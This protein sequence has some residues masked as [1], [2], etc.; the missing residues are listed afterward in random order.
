[1]RAELLMLE[2]GARILFLLLCGHAVADFALQTEWV[3][4]NKE[5]PKASG[6]DSARRTPMVWP[7]V[8][9]AHSLHHG[10][11]VFLITQKLSL[12]LAETIV[13]A[14]SDF[15]KGEGRYGFHIDQWIHISSKFVWTLAL[16][17]NWV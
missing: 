9:T 11:I 8:L 16:V 10:L 3:A 5:R 14:M 13:H 15:G 7:Y 17:N 2:D 4:L 1:M 6:D 12:G